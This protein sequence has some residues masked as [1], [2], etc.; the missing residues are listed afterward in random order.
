MFNL[1]MLVGKSDWSEHFFFDCLRALSFFLFIANT[2]DMKK[3][4]SSKT[5]KNNSSKQGLLFPN[6]KD[7]RKMR[8]QLKS[9]IALQVRFVF[10]Q[11]NIH[12]KN[13]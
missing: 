9:T 13:F 2:L 10:A 4:C 11:Q 8:K 3:F 1:S 6:R 12:C 5:L 7:F